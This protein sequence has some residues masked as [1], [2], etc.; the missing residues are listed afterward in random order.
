MSDLCALTWLVCPSNYSV[1]QTMYLGHIYE[2]NNVCM[3]LL[4]QQD[5]V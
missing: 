5:F 2:C 1:L 3:N 4:A